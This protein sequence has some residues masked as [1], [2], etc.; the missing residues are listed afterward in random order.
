MSFLG[1]AFDCTGDGFNKTEFDPNQQ[2]VHE[3]MMIGQRE[4]DYFVTQ[5]A[6]TLL[7]FGVS[8]DDLENVVVPL[9]GLFQRGAGDHLEICSEPDCWPVPKPVGFNLTFCEKYAYAVIGN[10]TGRGELALITAVITT[11][12]LGSK[13]TQH[14]VM[15][16]GLAAAS[17]PLL[18]ILNGSVPYRH[19]GESPP[20]YLTDARA[21]AHLAT[22]FVE[23]F[24]G[25][26]GCDSYGFPAY[27]P[28]GN[29]TQHYFHEKMGIGKTEMLYFDTQVALTLLYYGVPADGPDIQAAAAFLAMFNKGAGD[30]EI[31]TEDDCPHVI[32][33][34][35]ADLH[36][37]TRQIIASSK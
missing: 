35:R 11:T 7:S 20:D 6:L 3:L 34:L 37:H 30:N 31:C 14:G 1:Y 8:V 13:D 26:L 17:S 29:H 9:L 4:E 23:F 18:A 33:S 25:A 2:R 22:K 24:G 16:D 27:H 28:T 21:L 36:R 15:V 19:G 32:S 12:V 10:A 5:F